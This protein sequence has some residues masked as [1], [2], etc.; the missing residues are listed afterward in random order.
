MPAIQNLVLTDHANVDHNY[1]PR[2][3][4]GGVATVV[5]SSG[6]P[7]GNA[8]FSVSTRQTAGG[9]YKVTIKASRPILANETI[10]G[11]TKSTVLRTARF[12]GTFSF[13]PSSTT[14]ER[15][16]HVYEVMS[17]LA[18]NKSLVWGC[19]VDLQGLYR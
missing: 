11:V 13:D 14:S 9:V 16:N 15:A 17:A 1:I 5:E 7:Y 12:E 4:V 18:D 2:D 19:T 10:N 3:V 8:T 6:V